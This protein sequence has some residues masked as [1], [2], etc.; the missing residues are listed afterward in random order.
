MKSSLNDG[1]LR[2]YTKVDGD[3]VMHLDDGATWRMSDNLADEQFDLCPE[4]ADAVDGDQL[5]YRR[6][7]FPILIQNTPQANAGSAYCLVDNNK[8]YRVAGQSDPEARTHIQ[9]MLQNGFRCAPYSLFV[10]NGPE[11]DLQLY[12]PDANATP[13]NAAYDSTLTSN[14]TQHSR[15]SAPRLLWVLLGMVLLCSVATWISLGST[16]R[17]QIQDTMLDV[18]SGISAD[19]DWHSRGSADAVYSNGAVTLTAAESS[20]ENPVWTFHE[21]T[22]TFNPEPGIYRLVVEASSTGIS[23]IDQEVWGAHTG[24]TLFDK[25]ENRIG[26][27]SLSDQ[28]GD[29]EMTTYEEIVQITD[30]MPI[31]K[32]QI[33]LMANNG[34][35]HI[36]NPALYRVVEAESYKIIKVALF[37]GWFFTLLSLGIVVLRILLNHSSRLKVGM[38][39]ASLLG[40]AALGAALMLMPDTVTQS[41]AQSVNYSANLP[42]L[43]QLNFKELLSASGHLL[44]FV[45]VGL[46]AGLFYRTIS[47]QF[48]LACVF[49]FA[50]FTESIQVFSFQRTPSVN[51][52]VIDLIGGAIGFLIGC[53]L[54]MLRASAVQNVPDINAN[55][56]AIPNR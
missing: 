1:A 34:S 7:N 14:R 38:T 49:V 52:I 50:V 33:R 22:R 21:L 24:M 11:D 15:Q 2:I 41:I 18:A 35:M 6:R 12:E 31:V 27:F 53:L 10:S 4:V 40:V 25:D 56:Q 44:L 17:F 32:F 45:L 19:N 30:A 8:I 9:R 16:E 36:R 28:T 43:G 42:V 51:D 20:E 37:V 23:A 26:R 5:I 39:S 46:I 13:L 55:R 3:W 47:V 29:F 54:V 48:L